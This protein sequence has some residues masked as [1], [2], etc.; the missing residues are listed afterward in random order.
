LV[1]YKGFK[2]QK[3]VKSGKHSFLDGNVRVYYVNNGMQIGYEVVF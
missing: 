3:G 2:N 1:T